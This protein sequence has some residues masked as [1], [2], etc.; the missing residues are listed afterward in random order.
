MHTQAIVEKILLGTELEALLARILSIAR[1]MS[2]LGRGAAEHVDDVAFLQATFGL[3]GSSSTPS[4]DTTCSRLQSFTM[5]E[6]YR[7]KT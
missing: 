2:P 6:D 3:L 4:Q 7:S 1:H 5:N